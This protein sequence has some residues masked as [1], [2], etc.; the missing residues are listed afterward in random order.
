MYICTVDIDS[1]CFSFPLPFPFPFPLFFSSYPSI[2]TDTQCRYQFI[3]L[4]RSKKVP[5]T[6]DEDRLIR[7]LYQQLKVGDTINW[8]TVCQD[9]YILLQRNNETRNKT[10]P[11]TSLDCK[12]RYIPSPSLLIRPDLIVPF[13]LVL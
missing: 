4:E 12:L 2:Q 3:K 13:P 9:L 6:K 7:D 11:R 5:W 1:L 8:I 10:P